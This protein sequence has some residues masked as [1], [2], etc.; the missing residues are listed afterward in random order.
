M[1]TMSSTFFF[2]SGLQYS[3]RRDKVEGNGEQGAYIRR[4]RRR[5]Q[6]ESVA[7]A[8]PCMMLKNITDCLGATHDF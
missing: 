5:N 8:S 2:G 3:K 4:R 7:V 6:V 1:G